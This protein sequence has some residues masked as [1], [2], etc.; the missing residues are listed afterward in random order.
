MDCL[1]LI[2]ESSVEP[3][4]S[5]DKMPLANGFLRPEDFNDEK[6]Y[7]LGVGVC[8]ECGMVQLVESVAPEILFSRELSLLLLRFNANGGPFR[9]TGRGGHGHS[10]EE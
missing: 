8:S 2:C 9:K 3:F 5:F 10:I 6:R 7:K 1:C 4:L